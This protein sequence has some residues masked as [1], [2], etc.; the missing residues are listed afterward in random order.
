MECNDINHWRKEDRMNFINNLRKFNEEYIEIDCKEGYNIVK[1]K[2]LI[3]ENLLQ[4]KYVYQKLIKLK[5]T[6]TKKR[7]YKCV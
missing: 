2:V 4:K 5:E 1:I 7:Q 3:I 6:K